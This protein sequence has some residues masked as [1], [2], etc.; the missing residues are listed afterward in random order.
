[1]RQC[2]KIEN[3]SLFLSLSVC[4]ISSPTLG[5]LQLTPEFMSNDQ[6]LEKIFCYGAEYIWCVL[7]RCDVTVHVLHMM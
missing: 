4:L 6:E 1:M 3:P 5:A 2:S 7:M